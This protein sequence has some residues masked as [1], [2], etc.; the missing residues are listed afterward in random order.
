MKAIALGVHVV[1]VLARPVEEIPAGQGGALV[2]E[3]RVT[4]AGSAG[5]TALVLAKLGAEV[6]SAGA[7]G[8]D[9]LGDVLVKLLSDGA[10]ISRCWYVART[11]RPRPA[12]CRFAPTG[13]ALPC[14]WWGPTPPTVPTIP[15]GRRSAPPPTCT[16]A[17]RS[18]WAAR[19]LHAS[20]PSRARTVWSP[21]PTSWLPASRRRRSPTGLVPPSSTSTTCCPTTSRCWRCPGRTSSK[22]VLAH[23]PT[24]GWAVWRRPPV[25][26]APSWCRRKRRTS[27]RL[28]HRGGRHH[29]LRGR[30]QRRLP[31]RAIAGALAA[32][33][34]R[35]RVRRGVDGGGRPGHRPRGLRPGCRGGVDRV[36][37]R[38]SRNPRALFG[39]GAPARLPAWLRS[40]TTWLVSTATSTV[41]TS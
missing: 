23:C 15:H 39:D 37:L 26:R 19:P 14:T 35:A 4:A 1:D 41:K 10:W 2:E 13:I 36:G 16:S 6:S 18:S 24:A 12:C 21:R 38:Q 32:R 22:P 25:P 20:S 29:G 27:A 5:G 33:L 31:A 17:R 7:I 8:S 34:G 28:R 9:A 30:L 3:I 40:L 11:C